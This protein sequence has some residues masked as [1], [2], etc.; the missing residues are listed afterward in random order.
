MNPETL[1]AIQEVEALE[2]DPNKKVYHSF[3][4]LLDELAS[5]SKQEETES[6]H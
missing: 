1:S 4:E 6:E 5:E 2:K 3:Q